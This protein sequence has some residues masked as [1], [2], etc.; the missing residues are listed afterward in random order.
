MDRINGLNTIDI[1][2]GR[3]GFRGRNAVGGVVGTELAAPWLNNVQEE[4]LKVITEAG[5]A[6]SEADATQLWQAI[7]A[8]IAAS[9]FTVPWAEWEDVA[10]GA[11]DKVPPP[12]LIADIVQHGFWTGAVAGG[13][14]NALTAALMPATDYLEDGME[15]RLKLSAT[16]TSTNVTLNLNGL[17]A[18][19][20]KRADGAN[21]PVGYLA[22]GTVRKLVYDGTNWRDFTPAFGSASLSGSGYY[23]FPDGLTLQ[24]GNGT[25]SSGVGTITFPIAFSSAPYAVM[26]MDSAASSWSTS[27]ASF[28]GFSGYSATGVTAQSVTWNGS[29]MT[30]AFTGFAWFAI[31]PT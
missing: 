17:G 8:M 20:I 11:A 26:A 31:G 3:R 19:P 12:N 30:R 10:Y 25:T 13:T 16:N 2:G 18:K 7:G 23:R 15:I 9:A 6:P 14:A 21:P 4:I 22:N 5:L 29:A 28:L 27:N 24:W 1:G